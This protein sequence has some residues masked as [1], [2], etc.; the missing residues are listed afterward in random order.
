MTPK[1]HELVRSAA[2]AMPEAAVVIAAVDNDSAG[3]EMAE[4]IAESVRLAGRPDL[5]FERH[6][7]K[8]AKDWNNVLTKSRP[9]LPLPRLTEVLRAG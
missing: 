3:S 6:S 2:A 8:D 7:P 5:R 1:Q 9:P 4:I